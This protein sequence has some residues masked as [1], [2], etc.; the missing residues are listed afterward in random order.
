M[1]HFLS[2]LPR[3]GSTVLAAL[4]NQNPKLHVT[5][6]SGLIDTMG[7]LVA[8]WEQNP[9]NEVQGR[10]QEECFRLLRSIATA[11]YEHIEKEVVLDKSR[12]WPEPKI[13]ETMA[14]VLERP[15]KIVATVRDVAD[16]AA[17]FVR[18]AKPKDV[19]DFLRNDQTMQHLKGSYMSLMAGYQAAPEN[20]CI[21]DY[22]ELLSDPA[23]QLNRIHAFLGLEPCKYDTDKIDGTPVKERDAE[24]WKI[25]GLHDI[26]PKLEKQHN[27][28]SKDVLGS[29]YEEFDQPKF[30]KGE[31][32]EDRAKH[33]LDEMKEAG[34]HGEFE[35][36]EEIGQMLLKLTPEN[37]RAAYNTGLW[38]LRRGRMQEGM[39]LMD[40]GRIENVFGNRPPSSQ[41]LWNGESDAIVLLNCEGGLGDQIHGVRYAK[42]I[43]ARGCKVIVGCSPTLA[44]T[45]SK[46]EGVSAVIAGNVAGGAYHDFWVPSMSAVRP[47]KQEWRHQT[48][49]PYIE[50]DI[51]FDSKFRIGLRWEGSRIFEEDHKK[52]FDHNLMF[53]AVKETKAEFI[54]L[55]RDAS[56]E[57]RPDWVK[58]VDLST[59]EKTR[60]EMSQCDLI[61]SSCTSVAH[62]AGAMGIPTWVV[63]PICPY[64]IWALPGDKTPYYD[65]ITLFRQEKFED[66]TAPFNRIK[67][68]LKTYK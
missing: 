25:P 43:A 30:W 6:T 40:R 7:S 48:G 47:L 50:R 4:L 58:E 41:P 65:S 55:Q 67:A 12:G 54:S 28:N 16:C 44:P 57:N 45:F 62:M 42:D 9:A 34:Q 11:K 66:W 15:I 19:A 60:I 59:W 52:L 13:M 21:I 63:V 24:V 32:S 35:K 68:L 29:M 53:D 64:F 5:P 18:V 23:T 33:P 61:I 51:K 17:S 37:N 26:K 1:L 22:D 8:S 2:G 36:A 14:K 10:D 20:F 49:K 3:S 38:V 31:K 56:T 46:V 27:Q 39:A